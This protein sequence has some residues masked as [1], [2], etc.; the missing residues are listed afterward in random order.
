MP[1][2]NSDSEYSDNMSN[3]SEYSDTILDSGTMLDKMNNI[4][5]NR[6]YESKQK[7]K[8]VWETQYDEMTYDNPDGF[9]ASNNTNKNTTG[10]NADVKR[11]ELSRQMELDGGYSL[12]DT[13]TDG[14]YG[15]MDVNEFTHNNMKPFFRRG[16]NQINEDAQYMVN[17]MKLDT[18]TGSADN[19]EWK[20]KVESV[21]LFSPIMGLTN[22]NGDPVRTDE[23]KNRLLV[24]NMKRNELP[25]QQVKIT[26]GLNLGYNEVNK[27]GYQDMYLPMPKTVD[28]LRTANNPKKSYRSYVGPGQKGS[29]GPINGNVS[30][31]KTPKF[32]EYGK[33][34]MVKSKSY[35]NA[36]G[37]AGE[38]DKRNIA[39]VNRGTV[40]TPAVGPANNLNSGNTPNKMKSNF[41]ESRKENYKYDNPRNIASITKGQGHNN[42]SF[43]QDP[44]KRNEH[45]KNN[46]AGNI[47]SA[48]EQITAV[49]WN[50][51]PDA[52]K[53]TLIENM[54]NAGN[55]TGQTNSNAFNY[56]DV[57][58]PTKR[59]LTEKNIQNGYLTG[60]TNSNSFNYNDVND[61]TKRNL[62]ERNI[63][64]GNLTGQTNSNA[65]NYNDINDPTKRNL[66]ERN[67]QNG[68]L[69]GQTNSNAFNYNDIN[70]PTKRNLT[71]RN[72]QN[73]N[74]TGQT[75]SNAFNYNDVRDPTKRNITERKTQNGNITGQTNSN[76]FNY[77]DTPDPTIRNITEKNKY[78]GNVNSTTKSNAFNYN[79][80]PDPTIRNLTEKNKYN[81]NI[82]STTQS[83]AFNYNDTPDPTIRNLTEKNK[84]N[85]N[86]NSTTQSNAFNYNDTPDPTIRNMTEKNKYNGNII[87][88]TK[89]NAFNYN[90][91]PDPTKRNLVEKNKYNGNV[92][93][94]NRQITAINWDDIPDITKRNLHEQNKRAGHIKSMQQE[95]KTVNW[96]DI[97][98]PTKRN[99]HEQNKRA[100]H[101]HSSRSEHTAIDWNDIPDTTKREQTQGSIIG[102]ANNPNGQGTRKN[103][104]NMQLNTKDKLEI[105][106]APTQVNQNKGWT[107]DYTT[108]RLKNSLDIDWDP[109]PDRNI[110]YS[111]NT[112]PET[113]NYITSNRTIKNNRIMSYI[114]ENLK[115]NLLVI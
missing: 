14:T 99:L 59:N 77:N 97:P 2:R 106:S 7:T 92:V 20:H 41:S 34:D 62:T 19:P 109:T 57:N 76:A 25:F 68:N 35:I 67:I 86:I 71:E 31:Y 30:Q 24:S 107:T 51:L 26:P 5:N 21:P 100:G 38:Y 84:Y 90:D 108:F 49:D 55:I 65:F 40:A 110:I 56:N 52:T 60:Q 8:E 78:N 10:K 72:I 81:G 73:G 33:N 54:T 94:K 36:P 44:T 70:D 53:R 16:P 88:T 111:N 12:F 83:N 3:I 61:P 46:Y 15:I 23:F 66:T 6:K 17:K 18:F 63:Q 105:N 85:G 4:K 115:G 104:A 11:L 91:T 98:D 37:I 43:V 87:N 82:N 64:N 95:Y 112:K 45:E 80:T 113:N 27:Q 79:D 48:R 96:N 22:I 103:Y 101:I 47:S 69:T 32:K 74:I 42:N 93:N 75:N 50:D 29:K 28:M 13:N 39:T 9:V 114:D 89:S 58:D 1:S 102:A